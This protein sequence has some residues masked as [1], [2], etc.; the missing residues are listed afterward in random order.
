VNVHH[1]AFRTHNLPRLVAFYRE[2]FG[3]ALEHDNGERSVWLRAG[4]AIL[5]LERAEA[6]EPLPSPHGMDFVAFAISPAERDTFERRFVANGA[7]IETKTDFTLYVRDPD[8][9][10]VGVSHYPQR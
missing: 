8:G 2:A 4:N 6:G 5:M 3:F 7:A 1:I 9:R 10:R